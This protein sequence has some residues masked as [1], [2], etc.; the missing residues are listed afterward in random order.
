[1]QASGGHFQNT[2]PTH[3]GD[4]QVVESGGVLHQM[5]PVVTETPKDSG[6]PGSRSDISARPNHTSNAASVHS[7][8][9][10]QVTEPTS[11][12]V[13]GPSSVSAESSLLS[14]P[15]PM[16][17]ELSITQQ[18]RRARHRSAIEVSLLKILQ[19][20]LSPQNFSSASLI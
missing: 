11:P 5:K 4:L 7:M 19:P 9:A 8:P 18:Q 1:M 17:E 15:P 16:Q 3:M 6:E 12:V 14:T 10:V 13:Q 2:V 20:L